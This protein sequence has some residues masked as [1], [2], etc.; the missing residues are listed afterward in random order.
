MWALCGWLPPPL[1]VTSHHLLTHNILLISLFHFLY[2]LQFLFIFETSRKKP[3]HQ[4]CPCKT[5]S[6]RSS[7]AAVQ[8]LGSWTSRGKLQ[9]SLR[10]SRHPQSSAMNPEGRLGRAWL[11]TGLDMPQFFPQLSP[12]LFTPKLR[13]SISRVSKWQRTGGW[14]EMILC[15]HISLCLEQI[16][17]AA[18]KLQG[19]HV[20]WA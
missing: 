9:P 13:N 7:L 14:V 2:S 18:W 20:L 3:F 5:T 1:F 19:S 16:I 17:K 12:L 11:P 15:Q 10:S 6:L 8:S 4:F